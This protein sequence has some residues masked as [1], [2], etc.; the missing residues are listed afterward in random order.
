M[1]S[2]IE[3]DMHGNLETQPDDF[4]VTRS[5][6]EITLQL[7]HY[8]ID[9]YLVTSVSASNTTHL[10]S[11]EGGKSTQRCTFTTKCK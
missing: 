9:R 5:K 2:A 8:L 10:S 4:P 3:G 7:T 1:L 11:A 6:R